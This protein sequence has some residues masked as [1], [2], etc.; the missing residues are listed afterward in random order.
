MEH[1]RLTPRV[2]RRDD[3]RLRTEI[4]GVRQQGAQRLPH[5]LKQQRGHHRDMGEPEWME[6]MRERED[7][8]GM[9]TGQQ[10]RALEDQPA[11]GLER[12]AL[13]TGPVAARVVPDTG[14]VAVGARLD[15]T[16]QGGCPALHKGVRG[17]ADVRGQGMGLFVGGKGVVED[18]LQRDERHQCLRTSSNGASSGCCVQYH[19]SYPRCKRLVQLIL[20]NQE[21]LGRTGVALMPR[22]CI[23][24]KV[25]L[26]L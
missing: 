25:L 3:P 12:G 17:F 15:M 23:Q 11:L 2:Q 19:A 5:R 16:T 9:V 26:E 22:K 4:L 14:D 20:C 24:E 8:V 13:R 10:P 1:Q 18:R 7:D 21:R 6:I